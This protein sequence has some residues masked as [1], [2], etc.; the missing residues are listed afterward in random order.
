LQYVQDGTQISVRYQE[1]PGFPEDRRKS[2]S[3]FASKET[4]IMGS[5]VK[6]VGKSQHFENND[7]SA[8]FAGGAAYADSWLIAGAGVQHLDGQTTE[9][10]AFVSYY[11]KRNLLGVFDGIGTTASYSGENGWTGATPQHLNYFVPK[12]DQALFFELKALGDSLEP[13]VWI[14]VLP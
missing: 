13:T 4:E 7:R 11:L 1:I 2:W 3:G 12:D 5:P 9:D 14:D 10:L 6:F 8:W